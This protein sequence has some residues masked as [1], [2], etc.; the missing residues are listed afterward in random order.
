M[1]RLT[2]KQMWIFAIGQLGW[3]ILGGLINAWLVSF[4]LIS[5]ETH[6]EGVQFLIPSGLLIGG[7][8]TVLGLITALCRIW[9]AVTD[10]MVANLSDNSKNPKGRRIPFMRFAAIPFAVITVLVFMAPVSDTTT[11]GFAANIAWVAIFLVLFYTFMTIYCTPYNALIS[12]F[13]KTQEDRMNISTYISLTYFAGTLLAYLPFVTGGLFKDS[14]GYYWSNRVS[15]IVLAIIACVCMLIPTFLLKETDFV[16]SKPANTNAFKSLKNTFENKNFRI[17]T[18]SDIMYWIGLTLFQTGLP[19]FVTVSMKLDS[20]YTMIFMGAMTVLSAACYPFV[21]NFVKKFGKKKLTIAG[22]F[23]LALAYA[24]TAI[25]S[26]TMKNATSSSA[27]SYVFGILIVLVAAFPMALLG[28][29]P[30][31]IVADVAEEDSITTGEKR[32]GMFFAAR[33]FAMKL[34]QSIAMLAFTTLAI[35]GTK[36]DLS[37]NDISANPVGLMIIAIVAVAF[38]VLGAV[39]LMFYNEKKVMASIAKQGD[40]AYLAAIDEKNDNQ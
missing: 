2:K 31:S 18:G 35:I 36:Q 23:G 6:N 14:L 40:E 10:P 34:G 1:K 4:Y 26:I 20:S 5:E 22:F 17:F 37:K 13:G 15:F 28:I 24:I 3:S 39:I 9:D 25:C 29:I 32:E 12:E 30:Q 19:F 8:L 11:N 16:E 21:N 27:L 38:C 33:T 7:F